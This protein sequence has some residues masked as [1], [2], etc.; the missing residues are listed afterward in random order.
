MN[1]LSNIM[2]F[3]FCSSF[4]VSLLLL[5]YQILLLLFI[6]I[7]EEVFIFYNKGIH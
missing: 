5:D 7:L 4:K 2:F 6:F 3:N 1:L